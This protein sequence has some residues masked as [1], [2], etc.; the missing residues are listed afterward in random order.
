MS[1]PLFRRKTVQQ[2]I[3][4][5]ESGGEERLRRS[6]SAVDLT[7]IGIGAIIGAGIFA[8]TGSAAAT[9]AG[10]AIVL[11]FVLSALGCACA[12]LCYAEMAAMIPVAGFV[13]VHS[14]LRNDR[15]CEAARCASACASV[16]ESARRP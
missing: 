2:V 5:A 15:P 7:M 9:K 1:N 8:I 12:G 14:S 16:R 4:E 10:P 11:S 13:P 3:G 6:L